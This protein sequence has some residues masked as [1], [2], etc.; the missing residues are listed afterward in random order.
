MDDVFR[1]DVS[2]ERIQPIEEVG[3]NLLQTFGSL[4]QNFADRFV[5]C[6]LTKILIEGNR[7][8]F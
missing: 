1:T 5:S 4:L 8:Y 2:G 6:P 3:L 7:E